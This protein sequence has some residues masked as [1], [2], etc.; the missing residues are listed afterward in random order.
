MTATRYDGFD[1]SRRAAK[2]TAAIASPIEIHCTALAVS[3][4]APKPYA[5][6]PGVTLCGVVIGSDTR[7]MRSAKSVHA[8]GPARSVARTARTASVRT[9]A[10]TARNRLVSKAQTRMR[11]GCSLMA[12]P[13]PAVT[14][15][16]AGCESTHRQPNAKSKNSSGPTWPSLIAYRNGHDWAA[17]RTTTHRTR[18]ETG[19]TAVP[20]ANAASRTAVHVHVAAAA[21]RAPAARTSG[22]NV[23]G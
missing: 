18:A 20:T 15:S 14:P 13:R 17:R 7:P 11:P 19:N 6:A 5:I 4:D 1:G 23:G 8:A 22:M 21:G 12:A 10:T 3:R 16:P 9:P 2:T